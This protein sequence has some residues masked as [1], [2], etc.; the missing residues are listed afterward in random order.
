MREE[1]ELVRRKENK[2]AQE[3]GK[4]NTYESTLCY[5]LYQYYYIYL[6]LFYNPEEKLFE[7]SY[8]HRMVSEIAAFCIDPKKKSKTMAPLN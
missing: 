1:T 3:I 4:R 2:K 5:Y 6:K 8:M 7:L